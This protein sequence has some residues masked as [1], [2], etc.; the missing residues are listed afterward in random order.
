MPLS[1]EFQITEGVRAGVWHITETEEQLLIAVRLNSEEEALFRKYTHLQRRK[2]WLAYRAALQHIIPAGVPANLQYDE[3]GKPSLAYAP[4]YI[5]V[6]HAGDYA[7]AVY[8]GNQPVGIDI[9]QL[10]PRIER[11]K[12]RF[13]SKPEQD[14]VNTQHRLEKLY[15]YWGA[16]EALYKL[17]GKPDVDFK[18]DIFLHPFDYLCYMDGSS[19][20]TLT[21][22]EYTGE[23]RVFYSK[24]GENMLTAAF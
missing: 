16:K 13:L 14:A 19:A 18:N 24:M 7:A 1:R 21:T 11:V 2:Q 8:S 15:I 10:K 22:P 12:E 9:E 6:S 5:S 23:F 4:G 17:Y 20:A 3:H